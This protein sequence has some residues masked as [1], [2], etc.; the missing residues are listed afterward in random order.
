MAELL[1][2]LFSEE[3]PARMQRT[4][5]EN[6]K[7]R[8]V[9]ALETA[10]LACGTIDTYVTPRRLV[11]VVNGLP[12]TLEASSEEKRGPRVG[13]PE[14]ALE[15][16]CRANGIG[17]DALEERDGYYFAVVREEGGAVA[18]IIQGIIEK[19]LAAFHW[20][21]TMR[22]GAHHMHWVRPLQSILCVFE[23][24]VVPV[25]F[26]H[27]TAGN[28]TYGHRFL[29]DKSPITIH[30][31]EEYFARLRAAHVIVNQ[32]ERLEIIEEAAGNLARQRELIVKRDPALLEE[33]AGLV[34]WP[35]VLMGGFDARYLSLPQEVPTTVMRSHQK[36]FS[37][38]DLDG[39]LAPQFITVSN[40]EATDGGKA[41][42]SG[43]E[44]VLRA[45]LDDGR[46]FWDQDLKTPL[47]EWVKGLRDMVFHAKLGSVANKVE[48]IRGLATFLAVF[49]PHAGLEDVARAAELCKADLT[50]GMVGEFPE[51]Q[52]LMGRYYALAQKEKAAVAD[53]IRDHYAPQGPSDA[54]PTAPVSVTVALADKMDTLVGLFAIGEKPTGSKD[55]YALRRAALG[56]I[57][58]ILENRLRA[59]LQVMID[60]A[61][62][63]YPMAFFKMTAKEEAAASG[64]RTKAG[65]VRSAVSL[66]LLEFF[67]GRLKVML[68]E[69]GIGHDRIE[70]VFNGGDE[71][72]LFRLVSRVRALD[73]FLKTEDGGNLLAAYKRA[74]NIVR[75]EEEKSNTRFDASPERKHLEQEEEKRLFEEL[76]RIT[77]IVARAL[78]E[79]QYETAM[80]AISELRTPVDAFFDTVTVNA[81]EKPLR[82]NRL[83]LLSQ[84][85]TLLDDIA[86]FSL[87]EG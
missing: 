39:A 30:S 70:A 83:R 47:A 78:K 81:D 21:K 24:K 84:I 19:I 29:A 42:I 48:R 16:F 38:V 79:E 10:K 7:A 11:A 61:V 27:V 80:G 34:E 1:L 66:E 33:V 9:E 23:G 13:A 82:T 3:I 85:R 15:G 22:W 49:V 28:V 2:E 52:G 72:D 86:N 73:A 77:P 57:R 64:K 44:R 56:V 31:S 65:K 25:S 43:N 62:S 46:F 67:S 41:I 68:R 58:L 75:I 17:Q 69:E 63:K 35:V 18:P 53:A 36:Y 60:N 4:A 20:P 54:C 59:P 55:P 12:T 40:I 74:A 51:L 5:A 26:G 50:T 32:D 45:R 8:L 6:L 76:E 37:L 14:K 71:D 87:I